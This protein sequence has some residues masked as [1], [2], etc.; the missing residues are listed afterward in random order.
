MPARSKL[1]WS[2]LVAR[3]RLAW[4]PNRCATCTA[5]STTASSRPEEFPTMRRSPQPTM[6]LLIIAT[7]P[8][9]RSVANAAD[10]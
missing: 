9:R 8:P 5:A 3:K 7:M 6:S 1:V 2:L 10:P 4:I